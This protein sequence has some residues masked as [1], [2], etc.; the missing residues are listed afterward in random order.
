MPEKDSFYYLNAYQDGITPGQKMTIQHNISFNDWRAGPHIAPLVTLTSAE[1]TQ[2][3]EASITLEK[4]LYAQLKNLRRRGMNR[5]HRRCCWS[6]R[7]NICIRQ[8]S[9]IPPMSGNRTKTGYG[10]SA[11]VPIK[12]G[13]KFPMK[14]PPMFTSSAGAS[15]TTPPSSQTA[16]IGIIG[17]IVSMSRGRT[18]KNTPVWR[19]HS[20]ISKAGLTY[21]VTCSEKSP[22]QSPMSAD[23]C[24]ASTAIWRPGTRWLHRT[25]KN[26]TRRPLMTCW[27]VWTMRMPQY[28]QRRS[29]KHIFLKRKLNAKSP[30]Q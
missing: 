3:K 10:R 24:S 5:P 12:C 4:E 7:W 15:S 1:V 26:P 19:P 23:G 16:T 30:F 27:P 25:R 11:T 22:R 2:R 9:S 13:I 21:I 6:G 20:I 28:P 29:R 17:E 18:R 14:R 8:R